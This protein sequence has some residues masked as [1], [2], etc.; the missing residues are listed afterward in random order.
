V[1]TETCLRAALAPFLPGTHLVP[2]IAT[3]TSP[4]PGPHLGITALVH[5]NEICGLIALAK[6]LDQPP[7]LKRGRI[8]LILANPDALCE[9]INA[10]PPGERA[11]AEDFNRLWDRQTL[12]GPRA[13]RELT[14]ARALRPV[15]QSLDHLLDLHSMSRPA[16]P[17]ILAGRRK[18]N[19]I[20]AQGLGLPYPIVLDDGHMSGRRLRDFDAFDDD[21]LPNTASLI[22]CG[23]HNE[24]KSIDAAIQ[25][26]HR[27]LAYFDLIDPPDDERWQIT[28]PIISITDVITPTSPDFHFTR[29]FSGLE[30]IAHSGTVFARDRGQAFTTPYEN[31][32]LVMPVQ[33]VA[34]GQTAV[35][36]GR[37]QDLGWRH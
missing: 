25:T 15:I 30:I 7:P 27:F 19:L 9:S 3:L 8:S 14:R 13:S 23:G 4:Q 29:D 31:C 2:G 24:A 36:L 20:V 18:K 17:M 16:G 12:D 35:R 22:E 10:H 32:A 33:R 11:L 1:I 26:C 21:M 5:G 28:G 37:F 6:L 34:M